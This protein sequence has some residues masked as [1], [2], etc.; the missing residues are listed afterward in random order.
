MNRRDCCSEILKENEVCNELMKF[1]RDNLLRR[2]YL[3]NF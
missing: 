3:N 2:I 1:Q